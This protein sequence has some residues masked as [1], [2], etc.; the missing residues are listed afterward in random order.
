MVLPRQLVRQETQESLDTTRMLVCARGFSRDFSN[1]S[2]SQLH[3]DGLIA[4]YSA[5]KVHQ[6]SYFN[7]A[8]L[9]L[10]VR[11]LFMAFSC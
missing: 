7:C 3:S 9:P 6:D 5:P 1:L 4:G 8:P 2:G 10:L 11:E